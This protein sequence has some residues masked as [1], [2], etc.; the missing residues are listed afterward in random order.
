[1]TYNW[2]KT[3][4]NNKKLFHQISGHLEF[5]YWRSAITDRSVSSLPMSWSAKDVGQRVCATGTGAKCRTS[6]RI[7][8]TCACSTCY[9]VTHLIQLIQS[10]TLSPLTGEDYFWL[11][12][13]KSYLLS[14]CI[15][16]NP[17]H[18]L[19]NMWA[20]EGLGCRSGMSIE[21]IIINFLS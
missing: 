14:I 4:L 20:N 1:M 9:K 18:S 11:L 13:K 2:V 7:R 16:G 8:S 12:V 10:P 15:Y 21:S 3:W 6:L 17:E 19:P 5:M